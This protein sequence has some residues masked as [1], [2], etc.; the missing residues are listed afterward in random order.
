MGL[1][2]G[3]LRPPLPLAKTGL[4]VL[5]SIPM[6]GNEFMIARASAP[7]FSAACAKAPISETFGASLGMMGF[8][9]FSRT[10]S[11]TCEKIERSVPKA[12]P[13]S[14]MLGQERLIS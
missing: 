7:A 14:L 9:V 11:M 8:F 6:A 5:I 4:R 3:P 13:P 12:E 10:S 1:M 2:A